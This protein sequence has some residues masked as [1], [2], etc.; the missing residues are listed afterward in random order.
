MYTAYILRPIKVVT[1][2]K[3]I[4]SNRYSS[5]ESQWDY[6]NISCYFAIVLHGLSPTSNNPCLMFHVSLNLQAE[7]LTITSNLVNHW[8]NSKTVPLFCS[9]IRSDATYPYQYWK[10]FSLRAGYFNQLFSVQFI[11]R[12]M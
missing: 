1:A 7:P 4:P 8:P 2:T 12:S 5:F 11:C 10:F 6:L 3:L 9:E